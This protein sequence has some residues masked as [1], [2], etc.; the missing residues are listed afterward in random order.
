MADVAYPK[1]WIIGGA[2]IALLALVAVG[3][4]RK[5]EEEEGEES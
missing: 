3:T 1:K 2:V 4:G 5:E